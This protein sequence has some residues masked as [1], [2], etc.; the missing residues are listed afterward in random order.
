MHEKTL[1]RADSICIREKREDV[2][3]I[4]FSVENF[5][6]F[7]EEQTLNLIASGKIQGHEEHFVPISD[8]GKNVLRAG[9]LYGANA[10]GKSNLVNAILYAH[11]LIIG[12]NRFTHL[13]INHFRFSPKKQP[14]SFEF[15]FLTNNRIFVYGFSIDERAVVEEWLEAKTESGRDIDIFSRSKQKITVGKLKPFGK[16][17]EVSERALKA[18]QV[19]GPRPDQLLLNKIVDLPSES[20]GG[21]L[22][23]AS[24]WFSEC[25]M[26]IQPSASYGLLIELLGK[27]SGF[28]GFAAEFLSEIGTG[29][30]DLHIE[31]TEIPAENIPKEILEALQ[32][33]KGHETN[34]FLADSSVS[35]QIR[36]GDSTK[37][38]RHNLAAQ[39]AVGGNSYSLPFQEESD[40]TRRCL[41]LLPALYQLT[42][43][44]KVFVID[45]LDRSLH[46]RL[47]YAFL[48]FFLESCPGACQQL[49]VTTHETHLLDQELLR[50]DEIWFVQKD[51]KQQ[52]QLYSLADMNVRNDVRLEK[53]YL[54][55]RFGGIPFIGDSKKLMDLIKCPTNGKR[56]AKK[57][58][59]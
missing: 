57:T 52:T 3:L 56:H 59:A 44:C 8:T 9:V 19:L 14:S 39:H 49:I 33:P 36:A 13:A 25:L 55:G 37:V 23:G 42:R 12:T 22:D 7:G 17:A 2:V 1:M 20:R 21:L 6:S 53:G 35:L 43:G 18:L 28:R 27:D 41:N 30:S 50:R 38:I 15:R 46:P 40:G 45:E 47:S 48:K 16:E 26:V 4:N 54:Q 29:I 32:S 5:R 34:L 31:R 51:K 11:N 58:P 10:A 24:W